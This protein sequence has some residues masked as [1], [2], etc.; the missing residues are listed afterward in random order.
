MSVFELYFRTK[1]SLDELA[2]RIRTALS[3]GVS[4]KRDGANRGGLYYEMK[5]FGLTVELLV[6]RG[7][8]EIP[9]RQDWQ[10]YMLVYS[11]EVAITDDDLHRFCA[12]AATLINK[13]GVETEVD[14]LS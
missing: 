3:V 5:V 6:N 14:R 11:D 7:E 13:Q 9:E 12:H 8:V 2:G 4:E 10:Y 1:L